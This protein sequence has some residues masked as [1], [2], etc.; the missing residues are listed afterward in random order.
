MAMF[1]ITEYVMV[2]VISEPMVATEPLDA[3][4]QYRAR[5]NLSQ[6]LRNAV[7]T[8]AVA[9][10]EYDDFRKSATIDELDEK[11]DFKETA[12]VLS[13]EEINDPADL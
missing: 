8:L 2:R 7:G 4:R 10:V 3:Y 1:R 9:E 12:M 11:E 5:V 13:A 6:L